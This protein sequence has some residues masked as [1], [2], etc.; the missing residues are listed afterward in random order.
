MYTQIKIIEIQFKENL[1]FY[2]ILFYL[3]VLFG[4][5]LVV[6]DKR[7]TAQCSS[8]PKGGDCRLEV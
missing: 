1:W 4:E 5:V 7:S 2:V 3:F 8:P 6:P